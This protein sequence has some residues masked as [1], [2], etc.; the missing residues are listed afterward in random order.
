MGNLSVSFLFPQRN[1]LERCQSKITAF[2]HAIA[3]ETGTQAPL[4]LYIS[5][6]M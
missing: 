4:T 3:L 2:L 5:A 6:K 1:L